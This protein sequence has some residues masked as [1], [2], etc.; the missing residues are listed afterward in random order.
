MHEYEHV[1]ND[2]GTS[3]KPPTCNTG[4]GIDREGFGWDWS[5]TTHEGHEHAVADLVRALS[6]AAMLPGRGLQ[7]WSR[8]VECFDA[9]GYLTGKVYFGGREDVHVVSTS[10]AADSARGSVTELHGCRTA[11][12]DTRVDSLA[13]FDELAGL[14][15]EASMTYGSRV[16]VIESSERGESLG[17]TI[18]LGSPTSWVR[19][20]LY[21]KWLESPG[22]YA[23]GTNRVEVQ[24]RPPSR[25]KAAVSAW[26]RSETF[27]ASKVTR[28]V[29][30][31]LGEFIE[32]PGTLQLKRGTPDLQR[33]MEAMA[34]QYGPAVR[35]WLDVSG[36]DV[37]TVLDWLTVDDE[38]PPF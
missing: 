35:R 3:G 7:G 25:A 18:Y 16:T 31:M 37:G 13:D 9:G 28:D 38:P 4:V 27:G 36:G 21:Q 1:P 2:N 8:S 17:R 23:E 33:S 24:L 22:Q 30:M 12:V 32:P 10:A 19:I 26:T 29:A 6:P 5:A 15:R 11:R 34:A 20:R 14:L